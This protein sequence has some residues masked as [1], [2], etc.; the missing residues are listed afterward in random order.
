M[1]KVKSSPMLGTFN[2]YIACTLRKDFQVFLDIP[3]APVGCADVKF[4]FE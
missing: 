3:D 1:S 2:N 4:S